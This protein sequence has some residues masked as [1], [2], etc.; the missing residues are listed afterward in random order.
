MDLC[1]FVDNDHPSNKWSRRSRTGVMVF[2]NMSLINW[3][4]KKESTIETSVFGA[5]FVTMKIRIKTLCVIQY[6]LRLMG[7]PIAC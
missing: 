2:M 3:Y 5:E 6:K 4:S 1:T 7:I